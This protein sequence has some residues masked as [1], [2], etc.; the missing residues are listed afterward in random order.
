MQKLLRVKISLLDI[1]IPLSIAAVDVL[2]VLFTTMLYDA[3]KVVSLLGMST[4]EL[5]LNFMA[6]KVSRLLHYL[7]ASIL[8]LLY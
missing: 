8:Q 5:G 3:N 7:F 6:R 2:I 4:L 1:L